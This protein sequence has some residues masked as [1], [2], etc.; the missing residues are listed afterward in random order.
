MD[1]EE[2]DALDDFE[3]EDVDDVDV[4]VEGDEDVLDFFVNEVVVVEVG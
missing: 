4:D 2:E 1:V 3:D